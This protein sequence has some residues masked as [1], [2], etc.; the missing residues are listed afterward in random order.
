MILT[1]FNKSYSEES[2][3]RAGS[4]II[5]VAVLSAF[6]VTGL[7]HDDDILFIGNTVDPI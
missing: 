7:F 2:S 1:P 5:R 3:N 4:D 6:R